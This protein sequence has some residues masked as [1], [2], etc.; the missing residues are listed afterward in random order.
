M[1]T[2]SDQKS[3]YNE[4]QLNLNLFEDK[5][6]PEEKVIQVPETVDVR[7]L[8]GRGNVTAYIHSISIFG[9]MEIRFNATMFTDFNFSEL[10]KSL[11]DIYIIPNNPEP[12]FN[13]S[14][15]N[16]TWNLTYYNDK[17]MRIQMNFTHPKDISLNL[18]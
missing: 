17:V 14:H 11:V 12:D 9:E 16:F 15:L 1:I 5:W 18:E 7:D 13:M 4:Y 10:N 2:V 6:V 3:A 8:S